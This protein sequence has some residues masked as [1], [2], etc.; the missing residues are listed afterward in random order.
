MHKAYANEALEQAF[1]EYAATL[2]RFCY[3]RL[4]EA[5]DNAADCVQE[6]FLLYYKRLLK[7]ERFEN[8]RAFLYK[9]AHLMVLKAKEKYYKNA[10]RTKPLEEAQALSVELNAF[11]SDGIDYDRLKCLLL[12]RLNEEEQQLYQMKY[13][14]NRSL[15]EIA[16]VLNSNPA[17]VANRT[18]RLRKK[19]CGFVEELL[20]EDRKGGDVSENDSE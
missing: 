10:S 18:S 9:T 4:G 6:A 14:E 15:K 12:S 11:P 17:A 2:E 7:G 3:V 5:K 16:T 20:K 1:A 8:P 13:A 19:I